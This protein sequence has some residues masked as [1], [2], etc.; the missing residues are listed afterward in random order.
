[1]ERRLEF[2]DSDRSAGERGDF[3]DE[4]IQTFYQHGKPAELVKGLEYL[5]SSDAFGTAAQ[6][7]LFTFARAAVLYPEAL[8]DYQSLLERG[9]LP[10]RDYVRAVIGIAKGEPLDSLTVEA[11]PRFLRSTSALDLPIRTACDLDCLWA[12]FF[13]TGNRRAVEKVAEVA[14]GESPR[15]FRRL[16]CLSQAAMADSSSWR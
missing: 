15:V 7:S 4:W 11:H 9:T 5:V 14:H 2:T 10:N 13:L 3:F 16:V 1:M 12:E 8:A 6:I